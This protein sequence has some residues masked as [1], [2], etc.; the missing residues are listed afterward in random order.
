MFISNNVALLLRMLAVFCSDKG[1]FRTLNFICQCVE[2]FEELSQED[3]I[4][5]IK[6]GS[7]P[8]IL[9]RYTNLVSE[10]TMF[11]PLMA[12][13]IPRYFSTYEIFI[14]RTVM[15]QIT[16]FT[17]WKLFKVTPTEAP[18]TGGIGKIC[19]F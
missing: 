8:V 16:H 7:F 6:R 1:R 17:L 15:S 13:R 3:Q 9:A 11:L 4:L 18:V 10:K 5:L 2:G 14:S 19:D 12:F